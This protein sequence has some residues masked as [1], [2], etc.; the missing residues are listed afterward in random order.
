MAAL[1]TIE[2]EVRQWYDAYVAT[3]V[4][5]AVGQRTDLDSLLD[6]YGVPL[7]VVTDDGYQTLPTRDAVL[8]FARSTIES[9][10]RANYGGSTLQRVDIRPLNARTAFIEGV[11]SR[12]DLQGNEFDRAGAAYLAARTN[13]GWRVTSFVPRTT[14]DR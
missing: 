8:S 1:D 9:L 10:A 7:Q 11:F 4:S 14:P 6:F 12:H 2:I 3:F 5:L 13:Q